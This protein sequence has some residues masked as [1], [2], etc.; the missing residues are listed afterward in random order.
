MGRSGGA[1]GLTKAQKARSEYN[2]NLKK[3]ES[4]M[5]HLEQVLAHSTEE[6]GSERLVHEILADGYCQQLVLFDVILPLQLQWS[7]AGPAPA[8]M[9]VHQFYCSGGIS[10]HQEVVQLVD[11]CNTMLR[12]LLRVSL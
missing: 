2:S 11:D 5:Q 1:L 3:L 7:M 6:A 9:S 10:S 8:E 4:R 12:R